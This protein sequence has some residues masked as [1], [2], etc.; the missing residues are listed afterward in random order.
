MSTTRIRRPQV[1]KRT[2]RVSDG[3]TYPVLVRHITPKPR[4]I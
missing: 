3:H 2:P 1:A 4:V